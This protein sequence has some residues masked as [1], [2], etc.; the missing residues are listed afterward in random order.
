[1]K[2]LETIRIAGFAAF[3]LAG[4]G[5]ALAQSAEPPA[6]QTLRLTPEEKAD[7]LAH[8]TEASVDAARAGP[9]G[10]GGGQG[11]HGEIGVATGSHGLRDVYGVASIPLGDHGGASVSI[12]DSRT[13]SRR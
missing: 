4:A 7:I 5:T 10:S 3:A 1:M 9:A 13:A 6:P 12:E 11:I 8:Q 2:R